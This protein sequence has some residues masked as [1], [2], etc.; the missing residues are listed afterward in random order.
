M[1][2]LIT[3]PEA[4]R[5]TLQAASV[6]ESEWRSIAQALGHVLAAD[7]VAPI[8]HPLFDQTAVDGY[9]LRFSDLQAGVPLRVVDMVRAG[10]TGEQALAVGECARIFTGAPLPPGADTAVMQ[11]LVERVGDQVQVRDA[12]LRLG[13]NV[14][15][16]GEQIRAGALALPQG[17]RLNAAAIGFLASLG[18]AKVEVFARPRV[19]I[20]VTGDEFA[21]SV[22]DFR[23]GKIFESNGQML[24]AAFAERGIE[25]RFCT[26]Q[27]DAEALKA[28]VDAKAAESD[29]LI[30]TGGVSVGDYDFSRGA[31]EANDFQ[32]VFHQ[33]AQKPGKPLLFCQRDKQLAFGLPGNPRAVMMCFCL[34]V[35]P[36]LDALEG[37]ATLGLR[38]LRL[39]LA[40]AHKRKPDGKTHFVTGILDQGGILISNGQ[41]SHMLQSFA[42]ADGIV[43][44]PAEP[45]QFEAGEMMDVFLL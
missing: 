19:S 39:P 23:R 18:I 36:L 17:T 7:V 43:V 16:A 22:E 40:A 15:Y 34:Y 1:N 42:A 37:A 24:V 44:L 30:L 29:L 21:D 4:L 25:A 38:R 20:I 3:Y 5:L 33:V 6:A 2:P 28:M 8:D 41:A 12:G 32:V 35:L 26:C 45:A 10:D 14:R 13:G 11:E 27:D 9:A 31:L